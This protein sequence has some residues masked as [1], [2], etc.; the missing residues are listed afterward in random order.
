ME[1][2][3]TPIFVLEKPNFDNTSESSDG[4][5]TIEE[6]LSPESQSQKQEENTDLSTST[7]IMPL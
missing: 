6:T 1:K 7:P 4:N 3:K 2:V 5:R